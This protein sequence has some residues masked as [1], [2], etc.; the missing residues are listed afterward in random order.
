MLDALAERDTKLRASEKRYQSLIRKVQAAILLHDGQG[1]ILDS[2][3]LAQ[4]LLGLS[5]DQLLGKTLIDPNWHFL[6]EDGSALPVAEYPVSQ[7][8]SRRQP[9]RGKVAGVN[10]PDRD[11]VIWMLVNADP[12]YDVAGEI[13]LVI[14]SFV[15]ITQQK[16]D[17]QRLHRLNREL[18]AV[19]ICNQVLVRA[20]DE[21]AMLDDICRIICDEAGYRM[22][23]VGYAENDEARTVRP[24][25]WGGAELGY[26]TDARITWA[27]SEHGSGPSGTAIRTGETDCIQDLALEPKASRWREQALQRGYRSSIAL[28]MKDEAGHTFGAL[29]VYATTANDFTPDEIRLL[30]EMSGNLAFGI[31]FLRARKERELAEE[32][33]HRLTAELEQRVAERTAELN[34]KNE[35]LERTVRLFVGRELRMVQLKEQVKALEQKAALERKQGET[36]CPR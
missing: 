21:Q 32:A 35:D 19:G 9:V 1:R 7:V 31:L 16:R 26:L 17:E 5:A 24:V 12:E 10:R 15:D 30:E 11:E 8:L 25:S 34:A 36:R 6:R 22:A 23:W 33:L 20:V 4:E 28:P 13:A 14:V 27:D 3:P 18:R 29:A 2:N